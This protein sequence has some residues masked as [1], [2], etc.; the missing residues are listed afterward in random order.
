MD[1]GFANLRDWFQALYQC[2]LG[3]SQGPR[4]GSFAAVYGIDQTIELLERAIQPTAA[5][6]QG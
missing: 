6:R 3:H 1:D 5:P 4:M 2:L